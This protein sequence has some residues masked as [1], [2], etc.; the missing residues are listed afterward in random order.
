MKVAI[1]NMAYGRGSTGR[2]VMQLSALLTKE[3]IE[4]KVY[5][6]GYNES[7][8]PNAVQMNTLTGIRLHQVQSRL[9]GDQGWHST[10]QTV[11]LVSSLKKFQPDIV[12]LHNL[13][14]YYL[15]MDVLFKYLTRTKCKVIWTL[16]DCW[17]FTGHCTHYTNAKCEKWKNKCFAC[18]QKHAYPYSLFLDRSGKLFGR[19]MKLY[20]DMQN[21]YITTV[22]NWLEN[23]VRQSTLLGRKPVR[24]IYNGV[25]IKVFHP[26]DTTRCER[27]RILGVANCWSNRKGL[28][29]FI[30]LAEMIGEDYEIVLVGVSEEQSRMLPEKIKS[31]KRTDSVEELVQLYNSA[32][33]FFNP[34]VEETFGLTTVEAMACGVPVVVYDSTASPELVS[35]NVGIVVPRGDV[36][37]AYTAIQKLVSQDHINYRKECRN[38]VEKKY[39]QELNYEQYLKLYHELY[40]SKYTD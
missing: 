35:D 12:H 5:Y 13:H 14:G 1:I 21:L 29:D 28:Q 37:G 10:L 15:N 20:S 36:V 11:R 23:E 33:V 22:S 26:I 9:F 16:H 25:D 38:R 7:S 4:H 19:K 2:I 6:S 31:L 39:D 32:D 18:T 34:S 24:T 27:K 8:D 30:Q 3:N 17:A 40:S